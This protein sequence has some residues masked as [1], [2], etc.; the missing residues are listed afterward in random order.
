MAVTPEP[1]VAGR[2]VAVIDCGSNSTR[3]LLA[4]VSGGRVL[5][6]HRR[7]VIT[8]LAAQVDR[9]GRLSDEAV[10]RVARVLKGFAERWRAEDVHDVAVCATSAVRDAA[11]ASL[12][13]RAVEQ[14]TGVTPVVLSGV[15]EADLTFAGGVRASG[16]EPA[17]GDRWVRASG[18]EPAGTV[19]RVVCDIG[20]GSTELIV[21]R[22]APEH[23]VSL[24]LGGVRLRERHLHSDPPTVDEYAA[25]IA[26]VDGVLERLPDVF[27]AEGDVPLVAV[28]GTATTL[29]GVA[30]GLDADAA[31][32]V[33]GMVLTAADVR[34]VLERLAWIPAH[35]RLLHAAV[36]PGREDVIVAGGLLL[37]R[38][39]EHFGF[40]AVEV[41]VADLLDGIA[42]RLAAGEW[43]R[44]GTPVG[45]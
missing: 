19:R 42:L 37:V 21:G 23:R 28:A 8:R 24:Q 5:D 41:R 35:R 1:L 3:L 18:S 6:A 9:T 17:G 20:G 7:T 26:D 25:L 16:S 15:D 2:R 4:T 45:A 32:R 36:V 33:D 11:N 40:A 12:L 29:A 30:A 44:P 13:V 34:Q 43:P 39:L 10:D 27:M 38:V 31:D 22:A 14:A